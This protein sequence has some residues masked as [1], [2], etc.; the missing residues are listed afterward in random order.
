MRGFGLG[1]PLL[2]AAISFVVRFMPV[3]SI[4]LPN[5]EYWLAPERRD[6]TYAFFSRQLLWLACLLVC[7]MAG[8]NW[9]TI[10]ANTSTPVRMPTQLFLTFLGA[11]LASM[12]VWIVNFL[13]RFKR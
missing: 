12:A 2:I 11:Y 3:S 10:Q 5:R 9:L 8:L 13:R 4:N 1:L 7:F 6:A